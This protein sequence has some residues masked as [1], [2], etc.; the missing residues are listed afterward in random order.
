MCW[1]AYGNAYSQSSAPILHYLECIW[2][3]LPTTVCTHYTC[4][5][6]YMAMLTHNRL[7]PLHMCRNV[8][9]HAYSQAST[10]ITHVLECIWP[11]APKR[12]HPLH[13]CWNVYGN[14]YSQPCAPITHVLER[15]WQC[16]LTIVC[17]HYTCVGMHMAMLTHN[18]LHPL[19]MCWNV[20]GNAYSQP[21][22]PI[23]HVSE[24]IWPC[25]LTGV[26]THY[27]CVG[28]Y[29]TMLTHNHLHPLHMCWNVYDNA[30]SQP[31]APITH[32]L[33][34]IW[35][36]LLTTICTHYTCVGMYMA[37]LTHN[38]L[39][40]LHM[41]WN[42]YDNAYSQ[43][44]APIIHELECIWQCLPT[45]ICT[46]FTCVGMYMAMLTHRRLHPLHMCWNVYGNAYSQPSAPNTH[47]LECIW[48]CLLTTVCTHYTCVGMYMAMLTHN[49]LHPLHM[50]RNVYGHTYSQ[51]S[52]PITHVLECIWQCLLTNVCTHYT[53]V[54]MYMAML[55]HN[56]L[57]PLHM[58]R[59]V[60]G[61]TYHKRLHPL[62]M[63]WNVYGNAYSQP[64]APITDVLECIWPYLLTSV[65]T[66]YTCAEMYMAMLIHNR[67]H[68]LH[69]CWNV[70]GHLLPSVYTHYTCVGM[71]MAMITHNRLHPLHMC[72]NVYGNAYSQ[73][74]API[75]HVLECIWQCLLT[76][77]CTHYTCVG[78]HVA[79]LTHNRLHPL[80]MSWNAYG[81]AYQQP[82]APITHVLECIWQC[83]LTTVCTHYTCVGKYMTMLTHRRL[84]PLHMCWNVYGRLLPSVYTHYTCV[85]MY[86]AMLTHNR[87]H[88]LHMCWNAFGNA[89]SQSSAPIIHVLE[90]IW[91]CLL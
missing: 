5:G 85:G 22:V 52:T 91:Q 34:C 9:G 86:M 14:A 35:Q 29:M 74:F 41:C 43:S 24:C 84:H 76:T 19:H 75:T 28:M 47:V 77:V 7:H 1:N 20:Y 56:R 33:E 16:L 90:C 26:Y 10:P 2:Q 63:C 66:H 6:M 44:S 72:W 88:P 40:P 81:N 71:Y 64:S 65:Y 89:Y 48:Q 78:T 21:S 30:Y 45:T 61:H 67:L 87:L 69:M 37:M 27:T 68:P 11:L 39:H 32:V 42:A 12:L 38:R 8:Y 25:L 18:R 80:Y 15:I 50:C 51:A 13:M 53:C 59:N 57:H 55:T 46:H 82:S 83:L 62:H 23:T 17:T 49:R 70:Y 60:Y 73:P 4:V 79:M 36:C 54:G 58:C 3:C 31:S